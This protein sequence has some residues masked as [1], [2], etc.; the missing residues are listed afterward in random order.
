[1]WEKRSI[2]LFL[3]APDALKIVPSSSTKGAVFPVPDPQE[4]TFGN[5]IFQGSLKDPNFSRKVKGL[6]AMLRVRARVAESDLKGSKNSGSSVPGS[7]EVSGIHSKS[8]VKA[9][10][11]SAGSFLAFPSVLGSRDRSETDLK[12]EKSGAQVA[13]CA[14]MV[15]ASSAGVADS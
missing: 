9:R 15:S 11:V 1:M 5:V 2:L 6:E 3:S 13:L 8:R 4:H 10:C 14:A 12:G 7:L